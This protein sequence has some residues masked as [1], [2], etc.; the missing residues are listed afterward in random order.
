[1]VNIN[2]E[3]ENTDDIETINE[4][5]DTTDIELEDAEEITGDKVKTLRAKLK[6]AELKARELH[7]ELQRNKA[8]FLNARR[9]LEEERIR[10]RERAAITH[11][12]KLLPLCDSFY[13][14]MQDQKAIEASDPK[15]RRGIEGTY[16]QLRGIMDSY[17]ITAHDPTGEE[18]DPNIH[19]ALSMVPVTDESKRNRIITVIQQG[20]TQKRGNT[21]ELIRPARVTVGEMN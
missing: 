8:D 13:L 15:W 20:Y 6:E 19:E 5:T 16:A 10:D 1:M 17:G 21:E 9:R 7:E 2:N 4:D 3:N 11:V 18:F 12:E 14:A